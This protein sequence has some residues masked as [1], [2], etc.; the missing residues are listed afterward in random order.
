MKKDLAKKIN[1]ELDA[2]AQ[3]EFLIQ[4]KSGDDIST[5]IIQSKCEVGYYTAVRLM[6]YLNQYGKID[7]KKQG[8]GHVVL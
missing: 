1:D 5:S 2:K 8:C 7:S 6:N 4:F 3:F